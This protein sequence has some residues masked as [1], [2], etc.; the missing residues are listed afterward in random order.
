MH[1]ARLECRRAG[2]STKGNI[3][4]AA[5]G[6]LYRRSGRIHT[7]HTPVS[8]PRTASQNAYRSSTGP[9]GPLRMYSTC[10]AGTGRGRDAHSSTAGGGRE[11]RAR[12]DVC[13]CTVL[14]THRSPQHHS[15]TTF[16]YRQYLILRPDPPDLVTQRATGY[17]FYYIP[18]SGWIPAHAHIVALYRPGPRLYRGCVATMYG[19]DGG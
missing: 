7:D 18:P 15:I 2:G 4:R 6:L 16:G 19:S 17:L 11:R 13:I 12:R 5:M 14:G 3:F 1:T 10:A 8:I 9:N